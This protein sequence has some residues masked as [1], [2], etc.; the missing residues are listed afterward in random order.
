MTATDERGREAGLFLA[1]LWGQ[2]VTGGCLDADVAGELRPMRHR[3][4]D[5]RD[6]VPLHSYRT[7]LDLDEAADQV[8]AADDQGSNSYVGVHLRHRSAHRAGETSVAV[9]TAAIAEIDCSKHRIDPDA[10]LAVVQG[11]PWGAPTMVVWSGGGW[12]LVGSHQLRP[13]PSRRKRPVFNL[14]RGLESCPNGVARRA[15]CRGRSNQ[16]SSRS[17]LLRAVPSCR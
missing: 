4:P 12:H 2:S 1:T 3:A 6:Q 13:V 9:L 5:S 8:L 7:V 17:S 16:K 11:A 10:A 14:G 15:F